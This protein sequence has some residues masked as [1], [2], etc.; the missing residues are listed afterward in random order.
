MD[1]KEDDEG[2][3]LMERRIEITGQREV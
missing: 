2:G 1:M 3:K